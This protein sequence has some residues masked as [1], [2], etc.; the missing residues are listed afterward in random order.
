LSHITASN[1]QSLAADGTI[2]TNKF[3]KDQSFVIQKRTSL[4]V[5][6]S[7]LKGKGMKAIVKGPPAAQ[8][9]ARNEELYAKQS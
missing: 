2:E 4:S 9:L 1:P 3:E 5:S 6:P 7:P 8:Q